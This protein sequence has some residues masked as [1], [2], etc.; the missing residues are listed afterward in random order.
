M[1][2]Q[3]FNIYAGITSISGYSHHAHQKG[4]VGFVTGMQQCPTEIRVVHG[5]KKAKEALAEVLK[6]YAPTPFELKL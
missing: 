6:Q 2:V 3:A 1:H 4:L 5:E